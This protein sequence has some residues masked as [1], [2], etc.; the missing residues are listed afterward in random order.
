MNESCENCGYWKKF[1][2]LK[3]EGEKKDAGQCRAH[4]PRMF[5]SAFESGPK[6]IVKYRFP[7][8]ACDD[9]CGEFKPKDDQQR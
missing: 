1:T 8:T 4:S 6:Q 2:Q 9:W 5:F 7:F 3:F